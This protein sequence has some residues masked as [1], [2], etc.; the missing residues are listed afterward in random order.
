MFCADPC[1][2]TSMY[3]HNKMQKRKHGEGAEVS[4][5]LTGKQVTNRLTMFSVLSADS[6]SDDWITATLIPLTATFWS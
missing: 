2:K 5:R 3:S 6:P 4:E 1:T